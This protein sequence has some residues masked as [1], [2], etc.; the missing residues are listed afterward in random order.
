M[1]YDDFMSIGIIE[2]ITIPTNYLLC[3]DNK[4]LYIPIFMYYLIL[5]F[6]S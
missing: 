2:T 5:V 6:T 4:Q 3:G 1:C